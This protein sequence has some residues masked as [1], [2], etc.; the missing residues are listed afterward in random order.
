MTL[1]PKKK[2][3][4]QKYEKENLTI[5]NLPSKHKEL[6]VDFHDKISFLET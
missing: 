6:R 3:H 1:T 4:D 2:I 5:K